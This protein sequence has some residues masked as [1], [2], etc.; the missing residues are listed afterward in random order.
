MIF[1]KKMRINQHF[2]AYNFEQGI[3]L[4]KLIIRNRLIS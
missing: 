1:S 2:A 3:F 4:T